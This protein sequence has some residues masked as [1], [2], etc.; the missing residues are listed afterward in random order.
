M[1]EVYCHGWHQQQ[2]QVLKHASCR[3]QS[4]PIDVAAYIL[5]LGAMGMRRHAV[6]MTQLSGYLT[7]REIA[8]T[9]LKAYTCKAVRS[10]SDRHARHVP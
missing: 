7:C 8:D 6:W 5:Q 9:V 10:G 2:L 3:A 4:Y 1:H